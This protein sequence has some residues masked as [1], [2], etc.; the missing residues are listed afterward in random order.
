MSK[1]D[2]SFATGPWCHP[3][4]HSKGRALLRLGLYDHLGSHLGLNRGFL[5]ASL[6]GGRACGFGGGFLDVGDLVLVVTDGFRAFA[7][8]DV[9]VVGVEILK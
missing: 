3:S 8:H 7:A 1:V 9:D 4:E 2:C 6:E 5:L